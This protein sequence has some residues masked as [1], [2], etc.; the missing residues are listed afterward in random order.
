MKLSGNTGQATAKPH[1]VTDLA[2]WL[3]TPIQDTPYGYLLSLVADMLDTALTQ[4]GVY[5]TLGATRD[6]SSV[7]FKVHT[8]RDAEGVYGASLVELASKAE[9]LL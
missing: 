2:Q 8:G 9:A 4:D 6:K 5:M 1:N 3:E 7:T